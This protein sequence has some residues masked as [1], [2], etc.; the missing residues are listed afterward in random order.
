[1]SWDSNTGRQAVEAAKAF[2]P[3]DV[4]TEYENLTV[5]FNGN[6]L[7]L[8]GHYDSLQ[9]LNGAVEAVHYLL[10]VLLSLDFVDAPV[11]EKVVGTVGG[12]PFVWGLFGGH[13]AFDV[14]STERQEKRLVDA[15]NRLL[16]VAPLEQRRVAAAL[17]YFHVACR[18][19][20]AG[21][22]P[23]EFLSETLLN[24]SKVPGDALPPDADTGTIDAARRGL[25]KLG[26]DD[27]TIETDFVPVIALRNSLD[28][29]HPSLAM[30]KQEHLAILHRFC[31]SVEEPFRKMLAHV[32]DRLR[33]GTL[34]LAPY[35]KSE[36]SRNAVSIIEQIGSR[37]S[38][39]EE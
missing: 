13:Q 11:V 4:S 8:E 16:A 37:L 27:A 28:V 30:F 34:D 23:W 24:L 9:E 22:A 15:W 38:M 3:V 35:E 39:S 7:R 20:R 6:V 21:H 10:P 29:G 2:D 17:N 18:L 26:I 14:T 25:S 5:C 19:E 32:L 31:E 36:P 33:D 1:M 12:V